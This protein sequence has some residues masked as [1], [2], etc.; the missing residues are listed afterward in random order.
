MASLPG[1]LRR[2]LA[3]VVAEGLVGS[4]RPLR[5][6]LFVTASSLVRRR[7]AGELASELPDLVLSVLRHE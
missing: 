7:G 3:V 5:V 6:G 4:A 1:E 2:R